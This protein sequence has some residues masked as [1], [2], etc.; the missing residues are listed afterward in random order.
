MQKRLERLLAL[1]EGNKR[2]PYKDS[3]GKL[4]IGIGFNLDDVGLLPEE[5]AFIFQNRI[6]IAAEQLEKYL[7]WV[8]ELD[9]VRL[10]VLLDMFY[11]LGPE[12]FDNDGIKD[13]PIFLGQVKRKEWNAAALNML[14]TKWAKQVKGRATR[15]ATMMRTGEWPRELA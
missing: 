8:E 7:P 5:I 13:W 15:L 2:F 10:C 12:P 3:V 11:N 4:T 6:R 9:D 1:H 14:S